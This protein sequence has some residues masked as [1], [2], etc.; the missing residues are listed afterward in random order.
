MN[1][2]VDFFYLWRHRDLLLDGLAIT[3]ALTV[4]AVV[5][6]VVLGFLIALMRMSR[7]RLFSIPASAFIE[8]FRCTPALVQIVWFYY[9]LPIFFG[10]A[11]D[12]FSTVLIA[13]A[14]NISA[15]NAEAFRAAIQTVPR[16]HFDAA[17]ALGLSPWLRVRFV[18][19]PQAVR[20]ATP[21]LVNNAIG[22]FQQ[23]SLVSLV[24]VADLMYQAR[25]IAV[26][27]YRPIETLTVVAAIYFVISFTVGQL[28]RLYERRVARL[29]GEFG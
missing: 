26:E 17:S 10:L 18:V 13:L 11:I 19:F 29:T 6:G 21:V 27:T 1:Y 12:A 7:R 2:S 28:G 24:A 3:M 4:G 8:F 9:C 22:I 16:A 25:Q 23:S 5:I 14:L 15:F 20:L